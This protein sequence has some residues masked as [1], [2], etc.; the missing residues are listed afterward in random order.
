MEAG[1]VNEVPLIVEAEE[2][3]V[4]AEVKLIPLISEVAELTEACF[5]GGATPPSRETIFIPTE[6][7]VLAGINSVVTPFFMITVRCG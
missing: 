4:E 7:P 6:V 1:G 3:I 2:L 5:F